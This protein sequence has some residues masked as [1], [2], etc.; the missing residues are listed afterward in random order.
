MS[1]II[2]SLLLLE[3]LDSLPE[4]SP[5]SSESLLLDE[6]ELELAAPGGIRV[7]LSFPP[8]AIAVDKL[9]PVGRAVTGRVDVVPSVFAVKRG[10]T[11]IEANIAAVEDGCADINGGICGCLVGVV[12][13]CLP[14]PP[15]APLRDVVLRGS[16]TI[17]ELLLTIGGDD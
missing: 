12:C 11:G 3:P 17:R 7:C 9:F 6:L 15:L 16:E 14:R 1:I 2:S 4:S 5:P 8:M 10:G 13:G